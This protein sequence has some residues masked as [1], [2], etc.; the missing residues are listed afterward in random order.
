M[1]KKEQEEET[2]RMEKEDAKSMMVEMQTSMNSA[3]ADQG[4]GCVSRLEKKEQG[5]ETKETHRMEEEEDVKSLM[6]EMQMSVY[7]RPTRAFRFESI[8]SH[9]N[10]V[11]GF[12][13]E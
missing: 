12:H 7:S 1:Q 5:E 13:N 4:W 6:V 2:H 3:W 8:L 10:I 9:L 11:N